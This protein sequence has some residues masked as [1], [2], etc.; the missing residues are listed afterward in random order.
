M[1]GDKAGALC[2]WSSA[3]LDRKEVLARKQSAWGNKRDMFGYILTAVPPAGLNAGFRYLAGNSSNGWGTGGI[4]V[5]VNVSAKIVFSE[6]HGAGVPTPPNL[7][8]IVVPSN[9]FHVL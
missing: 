5:V 1:H 7:R 8:V 2:E 4:A 6:S 3:C 9:M